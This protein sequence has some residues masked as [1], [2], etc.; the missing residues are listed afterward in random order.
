M[1]ARADCRGAAECRASR[2][3][4]GSQQRSRRGCDAADAER[5]RAARR[6]GSV[7]P[8]ELHGNLW[9]VRC[10]ARLRR[11][12]RAMARTAAPRDELRCACGAWLRPEV[13]W[14]GEPLDRAML[15]AATDA[16][17]QADVVLVVGTSAVVYPVAGAAA[18]G[19]TARRARRRGQRRGDAA[20]RRGRRRAARSGRRGAAGVGAGAVKELAPQD[21]PRE[22]LARAGV[23][24]AR[25]Q[26]ARGAAPR[27]AASA[28]AS[29][30]AVAQDV[31]DRRP[32]A[33]AGWC[34][35]GSTSCGGSPGV[36]A[37]RAAR[38]LAAVEL[39]RRAVISARRRAAEAVDAGGGRRAICCR[40]TA[41]I[42]RSGLAW[43]CSTRRTA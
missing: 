29:A 30:L 15:D 32:A 20:E 14:F 42:G 26:R 6:A 27:A 11:T 23:G 25:R 3:S 10:A 7:A 2:R 22:K 21:R 16:V 4:R 41:A 24:V 18:V 33:C 40:C 35:S 37:P 9:R 31:L 8:V 28:G 13:V 12:P 34:T 1:A 36:G 38:L 19:A 43:C 5:R 17:E 39:G